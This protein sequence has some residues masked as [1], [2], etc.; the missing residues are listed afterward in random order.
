MEETQVG[1]VSDSVVYSEGMLHFGTCLCVPNSRGLKKNIME[2]VHHSSYTIHPGYTKMYQDL[3]E[4][5]W[6]EGMKKDLAEFVSKCLV[7]QQVKAEHQKPTGSFR[8]L[9]YPNGNVRGLVW[10]L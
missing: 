10:I 3:K 2:E 7:C 9:I 1:K 5:F 8:E 6:W 4:F